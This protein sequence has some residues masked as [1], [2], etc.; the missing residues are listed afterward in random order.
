MSSP[1]EHK[2]RNKR[3]SFGLTGNP[4]QSRRI[5][6]TKHWRDGLLLDQRCTHARIKQTF[7]II[8]KSPKFTVNGLSFSFWY[9]IVTFHAAFAR[10]SHFSRF[11]SAANDA[12]FSDTGQCPLTVYRGAFFYIGTWWKWLIARTGN[13]CGRTA[14]TLW[15]FFQRQRRVKAKVL[16]FRTF[17][18]QL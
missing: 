18:S 5:S 14:G 6:C 9:F 13:S 11:S 4:W 2:H 1:G 8:V 12:N 16:E 7:P 17:S 10:F 15:R 3:L